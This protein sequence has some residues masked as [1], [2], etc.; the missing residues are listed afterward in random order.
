[1]RSTAP[2][3]VRIGFTAW[4]GSMPASKRF[5][6]SGSIASKRASPTKSTAPL[7]I[8]SFMPAT[9]RKPPVTMSGVFVALRAF[10]ANSRK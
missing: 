3:P 9:E 2:M 1:M 8:A 6:A 7:A 10:S 5:G 4:R